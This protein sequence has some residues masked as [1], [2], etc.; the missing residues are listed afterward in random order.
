MLRADVTTPVVAHAIASYC[1][2]PI[3]LIYAQWG[4]WGSLIGSLALFWIL[5]PILAP[6][7]AVGYAGEL[8]THSPA[9]TIAMMSAYLLPLGF[10]D[11][12]MRA[13]RRRW[14]REAANLCASCGYDLRATPHRCPE[15]GAA[16]SAHA[17]RPGA[18]NSIFK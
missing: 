1:F 11:A 7:A 15:C 9:T 18:A 12:M 4:Q 2:F 6:I 13:R 8:S 10:W 5:A 3:W 14:D 17:R 16:P